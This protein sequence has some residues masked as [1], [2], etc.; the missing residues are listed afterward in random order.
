ML[1]AEADDFQVLEM[2]Q[3]GSLGAGTCLSLINHNLFSVRTSGAADIF[4]A[5]GWPH[6][7]LAP[8]SNGGAHYSSPWVSARAVLV[9]PPQVPPSCMAQACALLVGE[10]PRRPDQAGDLLCLCFFIETSGGGD[11]TESLGAQILK[12]GTGAQLVSS[13]G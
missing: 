9:R 13:V 5:Y 1:G 2:W 6:S 4:G 3:Y 8:A 10:V 12:G 7:L 11:M